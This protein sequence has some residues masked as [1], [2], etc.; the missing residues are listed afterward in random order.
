[1]SRQKIVDTA[2][3]EVGTKE[4]PP[5]SNMTKFGAWYGENGVKWCAIFVSWV[6]AH[7][8]CP[9]GYIDSPNGYAS[10]QDGYEHWKKTGELTK[11]PEMGDIVLY[12]WDWD[13]HCDHTGIF[14]KWIQEG[15][16]F[17]SYEG[18]TSAG[19]NSNGGEVML[20]TRNVKFVKAFASPMLNC[21]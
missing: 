2:A 13:G 8:G 11:T 9:L 14:N 6:Y 19:N 1:M 21:I 15:V 7:A 4:N 20:R 18:N 10:C 17:E 5:D 12:D 3:A 16:T